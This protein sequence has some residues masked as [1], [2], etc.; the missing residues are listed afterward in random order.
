MIN[1]VL[2]TETSGLP[3]GVQYGRFPHYTQ[4]KNYDTSRIVS[5]SWIVSK[6]NKV[7]AQAYYVVKPDD[8]VIAEE[9]IKIH[10]ITNEYAQEHG[11]PF[12][13][14]IEELTPWI[15]CAAG[16]VAHNIAFDSNVILSELHRHGATQLLEQFKTKNFICTM[17]KGKEFMN[18][19]KNPKLSELHEYLYHEP[20]H[21][22]HNAQA[23]TYYCFKCFIKMFPTEEGF[24]FFKNNEIKLTDE[25]KKIVFEDIDKNMMVIACAGSGKCHAKNTNILMYDGSL[26]KVQDI[27]PGDRV[28]GD[29]STPRNVLSLGSGEDE[30]YDVVPLKG[31]KFCVN[32]E[33]ILCVHNGDSV[34]ELTVNQYLSLPYERKQLLSLYTMPVE[35]NNDPVAD[36][37][38]YGLQCREFIDNKYKLSNLSSR[39]DLVSGLI[40]R[41]Q[42]YVEE[43]VVKLFIDDTDKFIQDV[44]FV[45][46]SIGW[47]ADYNKA[48]KTID[49]FRYMSRVPFRV[50]HKCRGR[51]YGFTLDGNHR[52]YMGN[53]IITHNTTTTL[54][55]IKNLIEQG[56]PENSI[57]LT[58]FTKD[59]SID[60][61]DKLI[62]IMGYK[63]NI[64]VGTID[65]ISK[66]YTT[67]HYGTQTDLKHVGEHGHEFLKLIRE[68]PHVISHF[69]YMFVDEFQDISEF[70]F[71]VIQEFYK[72]G[73]II[74]G[75]GDDAQNIYT[76]RGSNIKYILNFNEYFKNSKTYMLTYNFR[77]SPQIV[78]FANASIERNHNQIPKKMVSGNPVFHGQSWPKPEISYYANAKAQT[79]K[80]VETLKILSATVPLHEIAILCPINNPLFAVE[81]ILT[82]HGIKNVFLDGK[83]DTRTMRKANHVC[84]STIHK[85]KGLEWNV[86]FM[87]SM[88]DDVIPKIKSQK[89]IEEERRLFYVGVTRAKQRL[90]ILFHKGPT[91]SY[92]TRYVS[93]VPTMFYDFINYSPLR[94]GKSDADGVTIK[95]SVTKLISMLDGNDYISLKELG[96]IPTISSESIEKTKLYEA[97][98]Y[99]GVI[100]NEDLFADFGIFV[101]SYI[102]REAAKRFNLMDCRND[103]YALQT[104]AHITLDQRDYDIYRLYRSNFEENLTAVENS[105]ADTARSIKSILEMNAKG[106][107]ASH[108]PVIVS[109]VEKIRFNATKFGVSFD[110][111]PVFN[112]RFLP[113]DF[114]DKMKDAARIYSEFT[115]TSKDAINQIWDVSKCQMIVNDRRRRLLFKT[116]TGQDIMT[117]YE[118]MFDNLSKFLDFIQSKGDITCRKDLKAPI[119]GI[120]GEADMIAG[121]VLIDYKTSTSE[122]IDAMWIVQLL[123]YKALCNI[124]KI[125]INQIAIFNALTGWYYEVDV[126]NWKEHFRLLAYL[127]DKR[128]KVIDQASVV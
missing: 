96:I 122:E 78:E 2:D 60:M 21:N 94:I 4:L 83:G 119:D 127:L 91:C 33:H 84:L 110:K 31:D 70:Q 101:D 52:Y 90:Y 66:G 95:K 106:I 1:I 69:R 35:F 23:D 114:V 86:V 75:V 43:D 8:F 48:K 30:M 89:A 125:S 38:T 25:Q 17:K 61:R 13:K 76:F 65:G 82:Q 18:F 5:I 121:D 27:R 14:V 73:C 22:A 63:P 72:N 15:E 34:E 100:K 120:F 111:I 107:I 6:C 50:I 44:L 39:N 26:K 108:L 88:C 99:K 9:S 57:M 126:S 64:T 105:N 42:T 116:I 124:N 16:I 10:G 28:M 109:I 12:S 36:A 117:D 3:S 98:T 45:I 19:H 11:V 29:D 24:F 59:A 46:R 74:F 118:D 53:F 62:D 123:T 80:I 102:T 85:S 97:T 81:E 54:C 87:I 40:A 115:I 103:K 49:V 37:Y 128:K 79:I 93:E 104:L 32:G 113:E 67:R 20:M 92:V 56:V 58:T 71:D 112:E 51:Y 7:I 41:Y 47:T 55:R 68:E 77:S